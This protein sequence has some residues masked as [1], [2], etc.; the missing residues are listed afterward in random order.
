M[1]WCQSRNFNLAPATTL[2]FG[3]SVSLSRGHIA[4]RM[5]YLRI[6]RAALRPNIRLSLRGPSS[7]RANSTL[8]SSTTPTPT[9]PLPGTPIAPRPF[10]R[11]RPILTTIL[12]APSLIITSVLFITGGLLIY[13]ATTYR[14][15]GKIDHFAPVSSLALH[16]ERGGKKGLK[17]ARV[18][19]DDN[20]DEV[21]PTK[22]VGADGKMR[23][24][25]KLVIVG[26]GWG[27]VGVLK[28]LDKEAWHVTVVSPENYF[29]F[30]PLLRTSLP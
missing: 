6:A 3:A 12:I 22:V 17:L 1:G 4:L 16:P 25:Q 20:E 9:T 8:P 2:E 27:A 10:Y 21:D 5:S 28:H 26:G 29:L 11:R 15:G 19:V 13:D 30:H 23:E 7:P 24:K 14:E 18:L